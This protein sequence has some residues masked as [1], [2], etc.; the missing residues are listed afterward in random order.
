MDVVV[1]NQTELLDCDEACLSLKERRAE[2]FLDAAEALFLEQGYDGTSLAE[3]VKRSGGSLAT[4]YQLF[5]NK[6]GLLHAIAARWREGSVWKAVRADVAPEQSRTDILIGYALGHIEKFNSPRAVA[7]MK[8]LV[9]E[10]L[11][12]RDFAL[13][14]YNDMLLPMIA[15]LADQFRAWRDDGGMQVDDPEEAA[16]LFLSTIFGDSM[17]S[18]L[19]GLDDAVLNEAQIRWRLKPFFAYF[20]VT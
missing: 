2:A 19:A 11:R 16:H 18:K 17:L 1:L 20:Q 5:G 15:L 4:L 6:Q 13:Q 3:I 9:S 10:C 7:L 14:T 8:M 12:D